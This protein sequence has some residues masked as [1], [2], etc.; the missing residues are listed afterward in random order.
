MVDQNGREVWAYE[1]EIFP[2]IAYGVASDRFRVGDDE[3]PAMPLDTLDQMA[4]WGIA[5]FEDLKP[6]CHQ[7]AERAKDL[8]SNGVC[9]SV[10]FPSL[11]RFGGARFNEFTDKEL[12]AWCVRAWNDFMLDEWCPGG[13]TGQ[14]VP[15]VIGMLW[16]PEATAAEI[17]RCVDKGAKAFCW[18]ANTVPLGLPDIWD[19]C[20]DPVWAACQAAALPLCLHIGSDGQTYDPSPGVNAPLPQAL[21]IG[22]WVSSVNIMMSPVPRKF[23][24]LKFVFAEGGIGWIPAALER[25]PIGPGPSWLREEPAAP[26]AVGDLPAQHVGLHDRG[27]ARL[28]V[29][30]PDRRRQDP[31]RARLPARRHLLSRHR[32]RHGR[33]F[34]LL[35][36]D[37]VELISHG[38]AERVFDWT[39]AV[40]GSAAD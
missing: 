39:M 14:F 27:A 23:P 30:R 37:E 28:G 24:E 2:T 35:Q 32:G 1:D 22:S 3:L 11:P 34:G 33:R 20:W 9:A 29:P 19:D 21:T 18:V 17:E 4:R 31:C 12:A 25:L 8:Q 7:P 10:S 5:R 6:A 15:M 36:D 16:D 13:P 38:N 26:V 40:P